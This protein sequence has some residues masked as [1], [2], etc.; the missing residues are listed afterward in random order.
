MAQ[1]DR[2]LPDLS[3]PMPAG[4]LAGLPR[5]YREWRTHIRGWRSFLSRLPASRRIL[6]AA[7]LGRDLFGAGPLDIVREEGVRLLA[8][9]LARGP[10]APVNGCRLGF[11][12]HGGRWEKAAGELSSLWMEIVF[13]RR[14]A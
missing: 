3:I 11:P 2:F 6:L 1:R 14:G 9:R 10:E 7:S 5:N 13:G 8:D 4:A 12:H